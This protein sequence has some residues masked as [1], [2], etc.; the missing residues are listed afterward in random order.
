MVKSEMVLSRI[1]MVI[2]GLYEAVYIFGH[3]ANFSG[4][5]R[6]AAMQASKDTSTAHVFLMCMA[7]S[8]VFSIPPFLASAVQLLLCKKAFLPMFLI[9]LACA[10]GVGLIQYYMPL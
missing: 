3:T 9:S 2:L 6:S 4:T 8:M 5:F 10:I 1:F 7:I